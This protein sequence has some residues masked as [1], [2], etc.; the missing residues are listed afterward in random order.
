M[1]SSD[2]K[3][4][5]R[6]IVSSSNT[7]NY[8]PSDYTKIILSILNIENVTGLN[9]E[10]IIDSYLSR[11]IKKNPLYFGLYGITVRDGK[12]V[13]YNGQTLKYNYHE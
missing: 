8:V 6:I 13:C 11:E 2:Y 9:C 1:E 5:I 12:W 4:I 3:E 7:N 10:L